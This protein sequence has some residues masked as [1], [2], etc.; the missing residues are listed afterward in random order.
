MTKWISCANYIANLKN[1]NEK[2]NSRFIRGEIKNAVN[3]LD[4]RKE[5]IWQYTENL[6]SVMGLFI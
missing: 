1:V 2:G 3:S 4:C 5:K 6:D